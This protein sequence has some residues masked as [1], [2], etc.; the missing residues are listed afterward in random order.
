ME[1]LEYSRD[2]SLRLRRNTRLAM[3]RLRNSELMRGE[4]NRR[5]TRTRQ[6]ALRA[7]SV[8]A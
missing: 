1:Q 2:H 4:E 6:R 3:G 7:Y 8:D 5:R